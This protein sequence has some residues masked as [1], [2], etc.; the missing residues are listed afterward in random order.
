MNKKLMFISH[1]NND[2]TRRIKIFMK[3]LTLEYF[4][5][6]REIADTKSES[7]VTDVANVV[8]LYREMQ[9]RHAWPL[10]PEQVGFAINGKFVPATT[11]LH[12]GDHVVFIPPVAGG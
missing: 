6:L 10:L 2:P 12:D 11:E 8:Q 4:A 7:V 3:N 5:I 9:E 1:C